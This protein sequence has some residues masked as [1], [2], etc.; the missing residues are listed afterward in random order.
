M[1]FTCV[2]YAQRQQ[3]I[4]TPYDFLGDIKFSKPPELPDD[5]IANAKENAIA[6]KSGRI[7]IR[8]NGVWQLNFGEGTPG[9]DGSV[10]YDSTGTPASDKGVIGSFYL[11]R[12]SG[13]YF[14]K[15]T[16][17]SWELRGNLK[18]P[19]GQKGDPGTGVNILG[20]FADSTLLPSTGNI[21]D[22]YLIDGKLWVWTQSDSTFK[23]VGDIKGPK[24]DTGATGSMGLTGATGATGQRGSLWYD[25]LGAPSPSKGIV[26]DFYINR[27][28]SDYYEKTGAITWIL[29]GNL[30]GST[31][32]SVTGNEASFSAT[33]SQTN[34]ISPY[35]L[36]A[37]TAKITVTRNGVIIPFTKS[38]NTVTIIA[39]DAGDI[40]KIK[41]ID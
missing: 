8:K 9:K 30:K 27:T 24:G 31:G 2:L 29:R 3:S 13:N 23:N 15:I 25:S 19:S 41:W 4:P 17:T 20:E 7:Y 22:A 14:E 39:C 37:D 6:T 40:V 26:G 5:T 38:L 33:A 16:N 32:D 11:D 28:T 34:F 18:G 36:P 21:G 35:A 10:W 1:L 12:N